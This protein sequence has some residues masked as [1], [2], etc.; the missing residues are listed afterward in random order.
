FTDE[1]SFPEVGEGIGF[2][3]REVLEGSPSSEYPFHFMFVAGKVLDLVGHITGVL[4]SDLSEAARD[5]VER[6]AATQLP[7]SRNWN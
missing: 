2:I 7:A 3:E 4:A 5:T 6:G 1:Q